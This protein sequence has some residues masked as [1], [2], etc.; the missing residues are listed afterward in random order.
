LSQTFQ[1]R[2]VYAFALCSG[3]AALM[4]QVAWTHILSFT[5]GSSTLAASAVVAGFMGGMGLGAWAFH[6]LEDRLGRAL[7]LYAG[8]ELLIAA[9]TAIL[10]VGFGSLP[11]LFAAVAAGLGPGIALDLFRIGFVIVVLLLPSALMGATYPALCVVLIDS[12]RGVDLHL[13]RLYGVN[14]LGAALGALGTGM[15]AIE[16]LGLRSTVAAANAVNLAVAFGA[17]ALARQTAQGHLRVAE[18]GSDEP[19]LQT[20]LPTWLTGAVLVGSGFTSLGYEIVWFRALRYLF[21]NG[22]YALTVMLVAFLLGL[23]SGALLLRRAALRPEPERDLARVQLAIAAL[24]LASISGLAWVLQTEGLADL[25]TSYGGQEI[26][27]AWWVVLCIDFAT[28]LVLMLPATLGMGLSFPIATRL[29]IGDVAQLGRRVGIA[30]LLA[31][32]GSILGAVAAATLVL[33]RLGTVSGTHALV[34]VNG[35]LGAVLLLWLLRSGRLPRPWPL[36]LPVL[37]VVAGFLLPSRLALRADGA[38]RLFAPVL[39]W[40]E[41]NDVGTVQVWRSED[42]ERNSMTIDGAT[43]GAD[44]PWALPIYQKQ[45]VLAHLAMRLDPDIRD[46][47]NIGLATGSTVRSLSLHPSIE[48]LDAVEINPAVVRASRLLRAAEVLEDPRTRVVVEDVTQY[49]LRT[50]VR[51]DLIISDGKQRPGHSGN[52]KLLCRDFYRAAL[53]RLSEDGLLVQWIPLHTLAVNYESILRTFAEVFPEMEV[54]LVT[55]GNS[56]LVGSRQPILGRASEPEALPPAAE[57]ELRRVALGGSR[58]LT[59][60]RVAGRPGILAALP[61]GPINTWN[62]SS[63][64]FNIHR[65]PLDAPSPARSN[66]ALLLRAREAAAEPPPRSVD[67]AQRAIAAELHRA[68]LEEFE[69]PVAALDRV[70]GLRA[71]A[72]AD[73]AVAFAMRHFTRAVQKDR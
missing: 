71:R 33:P 42:G 48:R 35:T 23:G 21:G 73:P 20:A 40:E 53:D 45:A 54:F 31:N 59:A 18:P 29:F 25:V 2:V 13:G 11:G 19:P 24:S 64:E 41:E 15:L 70:M 8:L 68:H 52:A 26:R 7:W 58:A 5:F 22:T 51:Y 69:E 43:I 63:L 3:A 39:V 46:T 50:P 56:F 55:P 1:A 65:I 17:A 32:V 57:Q 12:Q 61:D 28:A 14:T 44:G 6:R 66:L 60:R 4:Y 27:F 9:T 36:A 16:W 38:A 67:P 34:A 47:L 49:L 62:H 37:L 10:T 30:T 72:P